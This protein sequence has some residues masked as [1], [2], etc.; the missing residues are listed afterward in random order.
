MGDIPMDGNA[1]PD[2]TDYTILRELGRGGMGVV[3]LARQSSAERLVALKF[4]N[5]VADASYMGVARF[6]LEAGAIACLAHPNV[7]QIHEVG[8]HNGCPYLALEYVSGGSL[9]KFI[10]TG[11]LTSRRAAKIAKGIAD[12]AGHAHTRGILHRDL[13]PENVL[14]TEDGTPKLTDFGLAQ[15]PHVR[16]V[17]RHFDANASI[18]VLPIDQ[19]VPA[20]PRHDEANADE[21][22]Q[23]LVHLYSRPKYHSTRLSVSLHGLREFIEEVLDDTRPETT[24]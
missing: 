14:L 2:V 5:G 24:R 8:L 17:D 7:V 16:D 10:E 12:G 21:L 20:I 9:R 15:F 18:L 22:A 19:F 23:A 1:F 13:K 6:R 3:Y 4:M 11:D